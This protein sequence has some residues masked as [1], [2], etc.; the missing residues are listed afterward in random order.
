MNFFRLL[1]LTAVLAW[2]GNEVYAATVSELKNDYQ[3]NKVLLLKKKYLI[4]HDYIIAVGKAG[5]IDKASAALSAHMD[6][7]SNI[8]KAFESEIFI[9]DIPENIHRTLAKN[10]FNDWK[11]IHKYKYTLKNSRILHRFVQKSI[12]Y[13][14]VACHKRDITPTRIIPGNWAELCN[15]Y[16]KSPQQRNEL[17][18]YEICNADELKNSAA[19]FEKNILKQ[20]NRQFTAMFFG[21]EVEAEK[22]LPPPAAG[23]EGELDLF[24]LASQKS[25]AAPLSVNSS[26]PVL[27]EAVKNKPY[28]VKLCR[29]LQKKFS[30]QKMPRCAER[31]QA[32]LAKAL[33]MQKLQAEQSVAAG[34]T[35][36]AKPAQTVKDK[37]KKG[38]EPLPKNLQKT[39]KSK[40]VTK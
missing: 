34:K 26:L 22:S 33:T 13:C 16:R 36:A 17:L 24:D 21:R 18:F 35:A 19:D 1:I 30:S 15:E 25:S 10:V 9:K 6:A 4:R 37:V 2:T 39:E 11:K 32:A 29:L 23:E 14:V 28:D 3:Q 40:D 27:I 20:T 31:M 8:I 38:Q 7:N 5:K 12:T